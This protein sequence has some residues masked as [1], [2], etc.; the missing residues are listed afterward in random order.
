MLPTAIHSEGN[1]MAI[2]K[3]PEAKSLTAAVHTKITLVIH[4]Q[5]ARTPAAGMAPNNLPS[6]EDFL[7]E[8]IRQ[9]N[10]NFGATGD[11]NCAICLERMQVDVQ[12]PSTRLAQ[13]PCKHILHLQCLRDMTEG[14][15]DNRNKCPSCRQELFELNMLPPAM[16]ALAR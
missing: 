2:Y 10:R 11:S 9:Q 13:L 16:E 1:H 14:Y 7:D 6:L 4:I 8:R 3:A 15:I 12:E 5:P